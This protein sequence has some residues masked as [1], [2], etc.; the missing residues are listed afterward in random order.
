MAS[1]TDGAL[2]AANLIEST[3]S[4]TKPWLWETM[5]AQESLKAM[6]AMDETMLRDDGGFQPKPYNPEWKQGTGEGGH[7]FSIYPGTYEESYNRVNGP[8]FPFQDKAVVIAL[9]GFMQYLPMIGGEGHIRKVMQQ[10]AVNAM[11][12]V[13]HHIRQ[14]TS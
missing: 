9:T 4:G 11:R 6:V 5:N 12:I 14:V 1:M 2:A 13:A 7:Q 10:K 8:S 3:A